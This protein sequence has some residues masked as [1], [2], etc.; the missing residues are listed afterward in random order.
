M[1][2]L[3]GWVSVGNASLFSGP[4]VETRVAAMGRHLYPRPTGISQTKQDPG[5]SVAGELSIFHPALSIPHPPQSSL[6]T[7]TVP[8]M[9]LLCL[10]LGMVL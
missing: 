4:V 10:K 5:K 2:L 6:Q 1:T 9:I 8:S 7:E 3:Q